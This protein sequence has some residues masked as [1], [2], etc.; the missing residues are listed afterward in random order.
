VI[1]ES[2]LTGV[3]LPWIQY[4]CDFGANTW[5]PEGGV[6][7]PERRQRVREVFDR[8]SGLG[9]ATVRWFML[10]DGRAGVR[11][12]DGGLADGLDEWFW[13]DL[14]AGIEE[15]S[16]RGLSVVF[17]LFDFTW[18]KPRRTV[19][20]VRCGGRRRAAGSAA[21]RERLIDRIVVPILRRCAAEPSI[22]A[23]DLVNEPEWVTFGLGTLNPFA[24]ISRSAMRAFV[25]RAAEAVH[26]E[27]PHPAT[28]GLASWRGLPL[29]RHLGLDIYQVHWYDRRQRR[30]PL[31]AGVAAGLE[32][33]LWLG[34]FPT[35]GSGRSASEI[36]STARA[37]GYAGALAWSAEAGDG[38][39]GE[40]PWDPTRNRSGSSG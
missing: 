21:A 28:V 9:L 13:R 18:W 25:G 2:F 16:K 38:F 32:R 6:A 22:A 8:L 10:C 33:P 36:I 12:T 15:S 26:A 1:L 31:E 24:S 27:T 29:V 39:S 14:E 11:F 40:L 20:G 30:A 35:A 34:E 23:W 7:R 3:N 4:G 37:A 19:E 5:Q 17:A